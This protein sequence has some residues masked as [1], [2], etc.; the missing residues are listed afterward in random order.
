[1]EQ[2]AAGTHELNSGANTLHQGMDTYATDGIGKLT[3][4]PELQ[5]LDSLSHVAKAV[6][7]RAN[8]YDSYT[9]SVDGVKS[10]VKFIY[11]LSGPEP[12]QEDTEA[13]AQQTS[14]QQ[15]DKSLWERI[16]DLF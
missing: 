6:E 8:A 14:T 5:E 2:F 1:M 16:K 9:G 10:S 3:N 13:T 7:D 11:K 4:A 15:Q 12:Q